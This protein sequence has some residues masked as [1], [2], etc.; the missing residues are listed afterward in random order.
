[1]DI[2]TIRKIAGT[3]LSAKQVGNANSLLLALDRYGAKFGLDQPHRE[4]Q[5]LA[6]AFHESG[7]FNYDRE[8]WGPTAQ[9]KK[10][11]TGPLAKKLGNTPAAD[12]DGEK[13][14]GRGPFQLTGGFNEKAFTAWCRLL[15]PAAP[16]FYANPDR[17]NTD[18]WEGLSAVWYWSTRNLNRYAD[19]GDTETITLKVNGGKNGLADRLNWFTRIALVML[20]Y[21]PTDVVAFQRKAGMDQIDG[22]AGPRTRAALHMALTKLTPSPVLSPS[23]QAAP[24]V[25]AKLVET[26]TVPKAVEKSVKNKFGWLSSI[27]GAGGIGAGAIAWLQNADWQTLA[28][29]IG[30]AVAAVLLTLAIGLWAVRRIKQIKAELEA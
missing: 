5:F 30:G 26:P 3:K 23:V 14:A 2:G 9:Q 15:D 21:G 29:V 6:Q 10:Y 27:F 22:D 19:Q 1:M 28:I 24:V 4:A 16:D 17:I 13:R 18:P 25:E 7:V 12:G 20:G 8:I 11:D